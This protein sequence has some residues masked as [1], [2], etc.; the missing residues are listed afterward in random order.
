MTP[1]VTT[2]LYTKNN[3]NDEYKQKMTK[4][5]VVLGSYFYLVNAFW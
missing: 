5:L 2:I 3:K 1:N 4:I